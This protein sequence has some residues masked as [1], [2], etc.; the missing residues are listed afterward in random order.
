MRSDL[1]RH[2]AVERV[3]KRQPNVL[4]ATL[5]CSLGD[6][7]EFGGFSLRQT[8]IINQV[9]DLALVKR[10]LLRLVVELSPRSQALWVEA[11]GRGCHIEPTGRYRTG[12]PNIA[13]L[14][15]RSQ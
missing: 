4:P 11:S 13:G 6:V 7:E 10:K 15:V 1:A 9:E 5:Q 14:V 8:L 3:V 12:G 2:S